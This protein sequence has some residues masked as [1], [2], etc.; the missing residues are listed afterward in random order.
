MFGNSLKLFLLLLF[1]NSGRMYSK[2]RRID[3]GGM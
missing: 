2:A 3:M 1:I